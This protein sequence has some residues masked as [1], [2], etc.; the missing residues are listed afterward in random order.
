MACAGAVWFDVSRACVAPE[1]EYIGARRAGGA[2]SGIVLDDPAPRP[3]PLACAARVFARRIR[4]AKRE[5]M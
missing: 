3:P 1:P 5:G 2:A 4:V